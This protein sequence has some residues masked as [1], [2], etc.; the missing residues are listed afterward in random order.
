MTAWIAI[1]TPLL[2][3]SF[4]PAS[5]SKFV[6]SLLDDTFTDIYRLQPF[7]YAILVP[8]FAVLVILSFYGLH[9]YHMIRGYWKYRKQ[10]PTEAPRRFEQLPRV[11]IQLPIYNEQYVVERLFEE[12]SKIDYPR[13][14]LEIQVLDDSTD[15]THP[16]AERLVAEYKAAGLPIEY[17]YRTDRRGY[18]AGALQNGLRTAA[19][20][21]VAVFDA[22][23]L[24]P[25]DFLQRTVHYFADP[26]V[27]VVQT[28]WGYVNRHYN[29]LTEVQAMLLDGHFVL[30]HVARCGG[31]KFF[32][33]NGTA[34]I[35][36]RSMIDDAGGWQHDTLTEDSDLSYRAQLKG[37]KFV[38]VPSIECKS[39]L[40][41]ETYG[42]QVQQSRWAKGLTQVAMKL[43]GAILRSDVPFK[44]K[45][46]AFFHLTPNIS[47]PLMIVVS[48]LMLPVMIVRFY[49]GWFQM[50]VIDLPLIMASFWSISAFYMVAHRE[51]FPN[52][53]KRA[54]LFLPPLM[55]AGVAL[56]IINS[57][58]V[59]EALFGYQ[60]AFARTP[61]Y[62]IDSS[63]KIKLDNVQ[64][65][66]H[67]GGLP[68][69]ELA[70]GT[71]FL[72]MTAFAIESFNYLAV[73]FLL[74]FVSGYYWAGFTTLWEEHQGKLAFERQRAIA[75][76]A[77]QAKAA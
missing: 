60:T 10:M 27:G 4:F 69:A 6:D 52:N 34:G 37:W 11:T 48:A 41:V 49:M 18:K 14:L 13:E 51:L 23:F 67:S 72:A 8:Y 16:F 73:P 22:D 43:L 55:A 74:L 45:A 31:G 62:A 47:Y 53:W 59:L 15:E 17:I 12:V 35:L 30:E 50:V 42:F 28:R 29:V 66:R 20:E 2:A 24:P 3:A 76:A 46:E 36:R 39:E 63:Q 21:F 5:A 7:D 71:G 32:N 75:A 1:P 56:T 70:V 64:Y 9:R 38:Y 58:A 77:Q 54:F 65:R 44:V 57:K 26:G 33:F 68:Y 61:K 19:G 40:P 25:S